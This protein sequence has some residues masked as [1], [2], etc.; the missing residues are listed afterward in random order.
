MWNYIL[1]SCMVLLVSLFYHCYFKKPISIIDYAEQTYDY[2][3]IGAGTSGCVIASRLSERSNVTVLLVE[4]GG[5]FGWWSAIPLAAPLL[6]GSEVDWNYKTE[7]QLYSSRGLQDRKQSLPRGKGL[8]GSGQ[9]NYLVHSFGK[10]EDYK[11]WPKGWSHADLAPYFSRVSDS[12]KATL[13]STEEYL[14]KAFAAAESTLGSANVT[15]QRAAS[16]FSNGVRWSTYHAYLQKAWNRRNLHISMETLATKIETKDSRA[17]GV[18]LMFKN[19]SRGRIGVNRDVILC[20]GAFNTPQLLLISGI[21]P[22]E[23][24]EKH[25]IAVVKNITEVGKNLFDHF[26]VPIFANLIAPVSITLKKMQ[27]FR[28]LFNYIVLGTGLWATNAVMGL[29]RDNDSGVI[30]FGM[31]STDENLL[32]K[33]ANIHTETY[34]SMFPSYND[35]AYEGFLYLASCLK[36]KSR[37][38]VKLRSRDIRD[39]PIIDPAYLQHPYDV[40]CTH[41]V[42]NPSFLCPQQ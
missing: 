16:T 4:A 35:S 1:V 27:S 5:Y 30:L 34:R 8:G 37:G 40:S 3:I 26:N 12:M 24:L 21:G 6:Q 36:P 18:E 11:N 7:S 17:T 28:Q 10:P 23:E 25:Q 39:S 15:L 9:M 41:R 14:V 32:R 19:G 38:T 33:L 42:E 2:I 13:T 22:A 31:G 20:A 29:A